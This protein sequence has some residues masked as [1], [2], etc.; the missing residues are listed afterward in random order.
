MGMTTESD[1]DDVEAYCPGLDCAV[2]CHQ[3][4]YTL[5][6]NS[7]HALMVHSL[8]RSSLYS[9]NRIIKCWKIYS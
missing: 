3:G 9:S 2:N 6:A 1:T 8:I 4:A 5:T 7:G